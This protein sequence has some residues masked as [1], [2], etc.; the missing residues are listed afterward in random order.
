MPIHRQNKPMDTTSGLRELY[1]DGVLSARLVGL[2]YAH[3]DEAGYTRQKHGKGFMYLDTHGH[4]I[5]NKQEIER[6]TQLHIPPAWEKVW[7]S[8]RPRSHIQATGIDD[9]G[10]KQYI[11][12]PKW[13]Q[14]RDLIKFYRMIAFGSALPLIR[15]D[16]DANLQQRS[17]N[18]KTLFA[19]MLWILDNTF[20]RVGNEQYYQT[21]ES[22]GLSTLT[23]Q[24]VM[25][26]G[27]I[28]TLSFKAKSGKQRQIV[29]D[30]A[31]IARIM[32][33]LARRNTERLFTYDENGEK[34]WLKSTDINR[35]L[36]D[37]TE[38]DT[39]AKDFRTWGGT[40]LA[41][42]Y[43]AQAQEETKT[44]TKKEQAK[45][46]VQAVDTA[47]NV[48]GNTRAVARASYIHPHILSMF[49]TRDFS[50]YLAKAE[51]Q[52]TLPGLDERETE[53]LYFLKRLLE[54]ER[55]LLLAS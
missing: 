28:I 55:Q 2:H 17:L 38:T 6:I 46:I 3:E 15:T 29:F 49:G 30:N 39:S 14:L 26:A 10:R 53:L 40:L 50:K 4:R 45:V 7:I 47:A 31:H 32:E 22:I 34:Q 12:H 33:E 25:V 42:D 11:Y 27:S 21:N 35:Y 23:P 36:R 19:T 13:R 20:I 48:L 16:I 37:L 9:R 8:P 24:N 18:R 52:A 54:G 44:V 51:E 1:S 41:F 5:Q 43:L